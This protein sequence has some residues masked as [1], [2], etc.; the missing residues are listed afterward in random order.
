[1]IARESCSSFFLM[2]L[3]YNKNSDLSASICAYPH[4]GGEVAAGEQ[5][6]IGGADPVRQGERRREAEHEEGGADAP[7]PA[8]ASPRL[9]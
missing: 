2:F 5:G 4:V 3:T 8:H 1:M 7:H 9:K 6:L